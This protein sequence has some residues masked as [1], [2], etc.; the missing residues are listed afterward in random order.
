LPFD[1]RDSSGGVAFGLTFTWDLPVTPA[2]APEPESPPESQREEGATRARGS[3][4]IPRARRA[5][6]LA[7]RSISR[8]ESAS[9]LP[10]SA[11]TRRSE[12]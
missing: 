6:P 3:R 2:Q 5:Q 4:G 8:L 11:L 12:V 10:S 1:T 9:I 7:S